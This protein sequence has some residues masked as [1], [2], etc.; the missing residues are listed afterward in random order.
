MPAGNITA[1]GELLQ[2]AD[3]SYIPGWSGNNWAAYLQIQGD[4]GGGT[5]TLFIKKAGDDGAF[6]PVNDGGLFTA[7]VAKV[8]NYPHKMEMK[9]TLAGATAPN[10][11]WNLL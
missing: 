3:N 11:D 9:L 7:D 2:S 5:V 10:I 4:F 6:L 1:D 8:L